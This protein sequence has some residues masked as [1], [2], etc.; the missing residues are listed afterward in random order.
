MPLPPITV[1]QSSPTLTSILPC[2]VPS[3]SNEAGVPVV[4][5]RRIVA[6]SGSTPLGT[7]SGTPLPTPQLTSVARRGLA[8]LAAHVNTAPWLSEATLQSLTNAPSTSSDATP[9][10]H[11]SLVKHHGVVGGGEPCVPHPKASTST[12]LTTPATEQV[13]GESEKDWIRSSPSGQVGRDVGRDD[14]G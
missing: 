6:V 14:S 1:T 9:T 5:R 2:T 11:A 7:T 10:S 3:E 4:T 8:P 12:L 13:Q